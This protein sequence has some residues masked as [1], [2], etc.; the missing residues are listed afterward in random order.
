MLKTIFSKEKPLPGWTADGP[1]G[2]DVPRDYLKVASATVSAELADKEFTLFSPAGIVVPELTLRA[3]G[4]MS[5]IQNK[6]DS[7]WAASWAV[8]DGTLHFFSAKREVSV[9]FAFALRD[10]SGST[11]FFGRYLLP[12][13]PSPSWNLVLREAGAALLSEELLSFKTFNYSSW[14]LSLPPLVLAPNGFVVVTAEQG[15]PDEHAWGVDDGCL[16]L[17]HADSRRSC[18]FPL[19]LSNFYGA[20]LLAGPF[21]LPDNSSGAW[22]F[23]NEVSESAAAPD[24]AARLKSALG[25]RSFRYENSDRVLAPFLTLDTRGFITGLRSINETMWDV[26]DGTGELV[27][28]HANGD[29]SARFT[30]LSVGE[31]GLVAAFGPYLLTSKPI[32][33]IIREVVGYAAS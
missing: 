15:R 2:S 27:F 1:D 16:S 29:I 33:H 11:L 23:L 4:V 25:G 6:S 30:V 32:F 18:F 31:D 20:L 24:A 13:A 3:G 12:G 8:I 28:K 17:Q 22:H 14:R 5:G 7:V 9:R 19:T 26:P 10:I 21:Q